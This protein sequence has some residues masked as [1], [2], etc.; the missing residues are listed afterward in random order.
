MSSLFL[1][2]LQKQ[3]LLV[4]NVCKNDS[5]LKL[6]SSGSEELAKTRGG[7]DST[8]D[9]TKLGNLAAP[10]LVDEMFTGVF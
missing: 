2:S 1:Y 4:V 8:Y 3:C 10:L 7:P 6:A 5:L 9:S